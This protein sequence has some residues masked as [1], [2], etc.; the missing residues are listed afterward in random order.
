MIV[1]F[2]S[3]YYLVKERRSILFR[4]VNLYVISHFKVLERYFEEV[5]E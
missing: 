4:P 3:K 5:G 2:Y 1:L